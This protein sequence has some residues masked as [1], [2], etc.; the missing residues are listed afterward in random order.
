VIVQ[1]SS[2]LTDIMMAEQ[3]KDTSTLECDEQ[4]YDALHNMLNQNEEMIC[5]FTIGP[6]FPYYHYTL[7]G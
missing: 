7:E 2:A 6:G 5:G 1:A 4:Q 3:G